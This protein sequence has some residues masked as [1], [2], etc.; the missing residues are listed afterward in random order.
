M[1]AA[2]ARVAVLLGFAPLNIALREA[3][4]DTRLTVDWQV[5]D[6]ETNS[7]TVLV[8]GITGL[9]LDDFDFITLAH[10]APTKGIGHDS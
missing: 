5:S 3:D 10:T 4:G 7:M 6:A 1:T 8:R 2:Q 9:T